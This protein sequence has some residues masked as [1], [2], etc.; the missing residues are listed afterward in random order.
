MV[1][2]AEGGGGSNCPRQKTNR[3][4]GRARGPEIKSIK[5]IKGGV[6]SI[7]EGVKSSTT[8]SINQKYQPKV[9]TKSVNQT[10]KQPNN[11]TTKQPNNQTTKQPNT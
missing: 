6:K 2:A 4:R 10:T 11:Q 8:K 5:S 3:G 7:K 1:F 9:S